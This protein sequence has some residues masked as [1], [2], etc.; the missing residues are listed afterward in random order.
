MVVQGLAPSFWGALADSVGRRQAIIGTL[1]VY[2]VANLGLALAPNFAALMMFRGFQALGS[3]A[4]ISIGKICSSA[5]LYVA[6]L[7]I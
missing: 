6:S 7:T 4:T 5:L 2:E 1:A 3:S